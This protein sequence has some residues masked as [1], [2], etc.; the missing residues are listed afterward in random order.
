MGRV[1]FKSKEFYFNLIDENSTAGRTENEGRSF[2]ANQ[3]VNKTQ[4]KYDDD[5]AKHQTTETS[6][7]KIL[8]RNSNAGSNV[9]AARHE[10]RD[11]NMTG[12]TAGILRI[13]N[14]H[15]LLVDEGTNRWKEFNATKEVWPS[16][17]AK[18]DEKGTIKH[19]IK[20]YSSILR[21][22]PQLNTPS[23]MLDNKVY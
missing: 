7:V 2:E 23:L 16:I 4:H 17:D 11:D 22:T 12:K 5:T 3:F 13:P 1:V 8:K 19:G 18:E 15:A 21:A 14:M 6:R 9:I 20:S 10:E